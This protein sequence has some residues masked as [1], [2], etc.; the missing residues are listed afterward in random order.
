[1]VH[2]GAE[3]HH[4]FS[5]AIR[6]SRSWLCDDYPYN[7]YPW[8]F[9]NL[10]IYWLFGVHAGIMCIKLDGPLGWHIGS[11]DGSRLKQEA[12]GKCGFMGHLTVQNSVILGR[13]DEGA[14][15]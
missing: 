5:K 15:I 9:L 4:M 11:P 12:K 1:M 13:D 8:R 10:K 3:G 2:A 14:C 7:A 6:E